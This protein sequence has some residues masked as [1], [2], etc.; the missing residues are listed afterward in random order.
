MGTQRCTEMSAGICAVSLW[1]Q[2]WGAVRVQEEGKQE[3]RRRKVGGGSERSQGKA[4][5]SMVFKTCSLPFKN[6][7]QIAP[8]ILPRA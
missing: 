6:S 2:R 7:N 3:Q 8:P 5:L 1:M 4:D